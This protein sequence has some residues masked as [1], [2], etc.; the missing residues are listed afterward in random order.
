MVSKTPRADKL[1][2]NYFINGAQE[3]YQWGGAAAGMAL[4]AL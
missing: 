1:D 2:K 3:Y 4:P